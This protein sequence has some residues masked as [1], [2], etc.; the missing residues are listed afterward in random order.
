MSNGRYKPGDTLLIE[1]DDWVV[2]II[3]EGMQGL[4]VKRGDDATWRS[5]K[6]YTFKE[7]ATLELNGKMTFIPRASTQGNCWHNW[8][9]Y[10]GFKFIDE[11][12]D[13]CGKIQELDWRTLNETSRKKS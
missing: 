5:S 9:R 4:W 8:V 6:W 3:P 2:D 11:F 7:L 1:G 10:T 12:C 13:K